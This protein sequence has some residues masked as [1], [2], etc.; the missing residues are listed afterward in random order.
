MAKTGKQ[1]NKEYGEYL[2]SE[3]AKKAEAKR[4][5]TR[6]SAMT[7]AG[8]KKAA[9]TKKK[10]SD[11]NTRY[12]TGSMSD[13]DYATQI[14]D[15]T[16]INDP[17]KLSDDY[18]SKLSDKPKVTPL[19]IVTPPPVAPIN[20][21]SEEQS[22]RDRIAQ[23]KKNAA[24]SRFKGAFDITKGRLGQERE[25]L[26]PL[27]R[28]ERSQIGVQDTMTRAAQEKSRALGGLSASGATS[29][30]NIAQNVI[31]GGRMSES[32]ARESEQRADIERRL[33]EAVS[34]REQG[35]ATAESEA[36][37]ASLTAQL[38]DIETQR[39]RAYDRENLAE[40]REYQSG[41]TASD[42]AYQAEQDTIGRERELADLT[43]KREYDE[44]IYDK[45]V[46]I[47]KDMAELDSQIKFALASQD[48]RLQKEIY[49]KKYELETELA[50]LNNEA[51]MAEIEAKNGEADGE[52][53]A[54]TE[55]YDIRDLKTSLSNYVKAN[56]DTKDSYTASAEWIA[57][58]L[59]NGEITE[60]QANS[61]RLVYSVSEEDLARA[62][63]SLSLQ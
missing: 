11:I 48:A 26:D 45:K 39:A 54:E 58:R 19:P 42:R 57:A 56:Q 3:A 29:Q 30:E 36:D 6:L 37:I 17:N 63:Y 21:I 51:A 52:I 28:T 20:T 33:S 61:L 13:K 31:T 34:L 5:A 43:S 59:K 23:E 35:I 14:R 7:P 8:K 38:R 22:L 44:T 4:L 49:G 60:L 46:Q 24:I 25:G 2:K 1:I 9:T 10:V 27:Y 50:T 55:T 12:K 18:I 15:T 40:Q 47:D 53:E 41:L 62:A 32:Q 16:K